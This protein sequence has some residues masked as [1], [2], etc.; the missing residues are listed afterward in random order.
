MDNKELFEL[1]K[2]VLKGIERTGDYALYS[3]DEKE[4]EAMKYLQENYPDLYHSLLGNLAIC[5]SMGARLGIRMNK[6][7]GIVFDIE[8]KHNRNETYYPHPEKTKEKVMSKEDNEP[9]R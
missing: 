4:Q 5:L 3:K 8:E 1:V 6:K 9:Q 2:I 7:G